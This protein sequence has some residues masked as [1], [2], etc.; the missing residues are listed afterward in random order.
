MLILSSKQC[1]ILYARYK[2]KATVFTWPCLIVVH[3]C[4]FILGLKCFSLNTNLSQAYISFLCNIKAYCISYY[5]A[6]TTLR[7]G[8]ILLLI[9]NFVISF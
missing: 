2:F 8:H 4:G 7:S 6:F 3:T 9:F 1:F 5:A